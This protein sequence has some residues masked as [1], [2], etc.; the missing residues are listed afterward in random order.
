[1]SVYGCGYGYGYVPVCMLLRYEAGAKVARKNKHLFE[2]MECPVVVHRE[3]RQRP[4]RGLSTVHV[5]LDI[6]KAK[7]LYGG[8]TTGNN[9]SRRSLSYVTADNLA[10]TPANSADTV[11]AVAACL[12]IGN[13]ANGGVDGDGDSSVD[14]EMRSTHVMLLPREQEEGKGAGDVVALFPQPWLVSLFLCV[15]LCFS[16][17]LSVSLCFSHV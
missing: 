5:E 16:L 4:S 8:T 10:I 13:G 2:G 6:T 14:K 7:T 11:R 1:M 15:S 9:G 17:F 12:G 3:L